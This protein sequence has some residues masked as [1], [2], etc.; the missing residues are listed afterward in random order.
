MCKLKNKLNSEEIIIDTPK[1]LLPPRQ[2]VH[3]NRSNRTNESNSTPPIG[4]TFMIPYGSEY[5][6][7]LCKEDFRE[8][9]NRHVY[10]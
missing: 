1:Y 8:R 7:C 2:M 5:T 6:S 10:N 3:A 4:S 9:A